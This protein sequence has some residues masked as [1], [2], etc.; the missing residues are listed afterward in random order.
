MGG[1]NETTERVLELLEGSKGGM[2]TEEIREKLGCSRSNVDTILAKLLKRGRAE[3]SR[4]EVGKP[5]R[6][7]QN[8]PVTRVNRAFVYTITDDGAKRLE[9]MKGQED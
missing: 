6:I 8:P 7:H 1:Y 5:V 4:E 9:A 2:T 3:R